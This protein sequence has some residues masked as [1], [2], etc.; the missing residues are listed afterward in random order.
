MLE[1]NRLSFRYSK[2]SPAVLDNAS[3]S[4][5]TGKIGVLL[6][7]NGSG[8][9][10]LFKNILGLC[11]PVAGTI[12]FDGTNLSSLSHRERAG[13]IGYVPQQIQFGNL[14][15]FDSI[16]SGRISYF[17]MRAGKEDYAEVQRIIDELNLD[18]IAWKNAEELSGGEK[19]K[20]AIA[21]ALAQNPKILIFDEPTGNL[22]MA[23][24]YLI[25]REARKIARDKNITILSSFH[26]LNQA[27]SLGDMFFFMKDGNVRYSGDE[28][29]ITE[30]VIRDVYGI[31]T[32]IMEIDGRKV[33]I[34]GS[35]E[36]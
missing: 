19:Q 12:S 28:K 25:I 14:T 20:V 8:K 22:D 13:M 21:R 23:N 30:D 4:L 31:S 24:E 26:D 3:L 6:G 17:G 34:G 32:K 35:Y 11:R 29:V 36:E 15:V 33:V 5:E 2:S 7:K 16:L 9:T 1:V 27:M 18:S 10:T